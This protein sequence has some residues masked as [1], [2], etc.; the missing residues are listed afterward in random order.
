MA[1]PR[2]QAPKLWITSTS[3]AETPRSPIF[4]GLHRGQ[5][6]LLRL[7]WALEVF[8]LLLEMLDGLLQHILKVHGALVDILDQVVIQL[9]LGD[10]H[11][12][13]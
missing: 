12:L 7:T 2:S 6:K 1:T 10:V 11:R 4:S 9:H 8:G 13:G 5:R 3:Y